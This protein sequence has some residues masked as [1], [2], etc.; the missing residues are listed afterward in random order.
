MSYYSLDG[1]Y[2]R[3]RPTL[4][5]GRIQGV[6]KPTRAGLGVFTGYSLPI[7]NDDDEELYYRTI[8]PARYNGTDNPTAKLYVYLSGAEDVGDTF[9]FQLGYNII[10]CDGTIVPS[11]VLTTDKE[12]TIT[13][14]HSAQNSIYC[15]D[16]PITAAG[17][18]DQVAAG[19]IRRIA[20]SGTEVTN[21]IVAMY[22]E[23]QYPVNKIFGGK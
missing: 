15:V 3:I 10:D 4:D 6:L 7:Y 17:A 22:F 11:E 1:R 16:M 5:Q 19:R 20:S 2:I 9:K 13:T 23:I 14:G 12:I 18:V 21:E 8:T